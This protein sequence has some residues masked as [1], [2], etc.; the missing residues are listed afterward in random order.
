MLLRLLLLR[1][2]CTDVNMWA[3]GKES[4]GRDSGADRLHRTFTYI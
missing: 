4:P 3:D 1:G 2:C